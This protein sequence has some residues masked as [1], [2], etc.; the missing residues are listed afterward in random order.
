MANEIRTAFKF[1]LWRANVN[2]RSSPQ[3]Q[4][5]V[6]TTSELYSDNTQSVGT[7]HEAVAAG[8]VT[9][10]AMLIVENLHATATVEIGGDSG[11]SFVS[12]LTIPPGYPAAVLP[13]ASSLASTYL[14]SDTAA[15]PVRVTLCK[16]V[17]PV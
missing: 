6:E 3:K 12:W 10:D 16:I 2:V 8:D 9:D 17:A 7:T 15:T 11:G 4:V 5:S 1:D 14:K 13:V